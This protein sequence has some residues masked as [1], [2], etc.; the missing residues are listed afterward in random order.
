MVLTTK[1]DSEEKKML[2]LVAGMLLI[3]L[4]A[5]LLRFPD[6]VE[7]LRKNDH[8]QWELLGSP[9]AYAFSKTI[10]VFS[11]VLSRGYEN[12]SSTEVS[13][14]GSEAF[15]KAIFAKYSLLIGVAL[16]AGGFF[17]AVAMAA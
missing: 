3:V 5:S 4:G 17:V 13:A 1:E 9:P 10:G 8:S 15:K 14:L 11:W 6:L 16:V 7:S 12:S 2:I